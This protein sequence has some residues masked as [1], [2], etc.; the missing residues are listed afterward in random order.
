MNRKVV[1]A[2]VLAIS[3]LLEVPFYS[4]S[5]ANVFG[6]AHPDELLAPGETGEPVTIS[7]TNLGSTLFNV[8]VIPMSVY[9]FSPY[10]Y[11]NDTENISIPYW[12]QGQTVNV[13]V[14][15]NVASSAKDG[16]YKYYVMVS[17][18]D[19]N[20]NQEEKTIVVSIPVLGKEQVSAQSVW[21]TTNSS[22]V[23]GPGEDNVPLTI[24]LQ[25]QGNVMLSNVTLHLK[26][27]Y[28][29]KFLQDNVSVGYLPIGQPIPVT[30][31]ADVYP[32]AT[33]GVHYVEANITFFNDSSE[34]VKIP[35]DII[36]TNQVSLETLWGSTSS[37]II[38][39][40][41]EAN[42]PLTIIVKNLETNLLSNVSLEFKST[43]P[44]KFLQPNASVG[45]V[46]PGEYNEVSVT[47]DVYNNA[48]PGV[49]YV[50]VTLTLYGGE[51]MKV[52]M[53]ITIA[54]TVN[55]SMNMYTF[56]PQVFQ[57][58]SDV[59]LH[60]LLLNYGSGIAQNASV[61]IK[62]P[63]GINLISQPEQQIGAIPSGKLINTSFLF[64]VPNTTSPGNYEIN[65]TVNYDGGHYTNA[66]TLEIYPKANIIIYSTYFPGA[67]AGASKI[68]LTITLENIGNETAKN[69]VLRLG[70]SDVIYPHVS[71]SNPL[72]ALT[73]SEYFIGDIKPG[74]KVNVTYIVDVSSGATPG[75]YPLSVALEWNQTGS[76]YPFVQ[77]DTFNATVHEPF[78]SKLV[79]SNTLL[80]LIFVIII[81]VLIIALI[82]VARRR[83]SPK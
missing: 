79:S 83:G 58:Y 47:A 10:G 8:S 51:T 17:G 64:N 3:F 69:V 5:T 42:L 11:Y 70:E 57:G 72:Q 21:G 23:V 25:N 36:S 63:N 49:Y 75:T 26:S 77:S 40:A 48:T 31:L 35:V 74:Q 53:P 27:N 20:G 73:A 65:V 56:P 81:I 76:L 1:L 33:E 14:L 55:I 15:L 19:E 46:P 22:M 38:A 6:Y 82:A 41:G 4:A 37:P 59:E 78:L 52:E 29:V 39:S 16:I 7:L 68:P 13:T 32:N 60:V 44:V 61:Q 66:Y 18:Y 80:I 28:P 34:T 67:T 30:V 24:L 54:G 62:T 12:G 43:Y 50:P 45:L 2:L 9:P 71:S